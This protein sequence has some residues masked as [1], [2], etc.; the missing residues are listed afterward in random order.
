MIYNGD[1][2]DILPQLEDE[3]IDLLVTDPPYGIGFMGKDWDKA[4]LLNRECIGIELEEKYIEIAKHRCSQKV[5][6]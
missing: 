2:L 6:V 1:C 4:L 3:S 5:L